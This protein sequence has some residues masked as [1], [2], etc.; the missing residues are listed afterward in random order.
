MD[1]L[2][3]RAGA[4]GDILLLRRSVA[5]LRSAG[6]RVRL[7]APA[8][9][10]V[11]VGPGLGEVDALLRWDAPEL[12]ALLAGT[13]AARGPVVDG[14][15]AADAVVA[16]TRSEDVARALGRIVRRL[17]THDPSPPPGQ[18]SRRSEGAGTTPDAARTG[19][20]SHWL[21]R[22]LE[23]LGLEA[24]ADPPLLSF[25]REEH[26]QAAR[27]LASL[28]ARFLAIHPGSGSTAKNWAAERFLDF[29]RRWTAGPR[30]ENLDEPF[31][32]SL[33]PA[34][35][36]RGL[37][38]PPGA[39]TAREW[40][41]RVLGAALARAGL[42]LGNDSG[43]SHLAAA[44][45]T[46]TLALFGPSDPAVWAPVG[47]S[48]R[49]MRAPGFALDALR[50]ADVVRTARRFT[51]EASGRPPIPSRRRP[52]TEDRGIPVRVSSR[53]RASRARERTSRR[54]SG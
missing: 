45:G 8:V 54:R 37:A 27:R 49:T 31:L 5:A 35:A 32:L 50:V 20:A 43:A 30:D 39:L 51:T 7:V 23:P 29:A 9:G 24:A 19:H 44:A 22:A 16:W 11:L 52:R 10:A 34:E 25:T 14:L 53:E 1:V 2:L 41:L 42:Y 18:P 6:H 47:P 36:E 3:V 40:P 15:A 26:D 48:V 13:P 17:L 21:A 28:P 46:P 12:A 33:G 4:L 38:A